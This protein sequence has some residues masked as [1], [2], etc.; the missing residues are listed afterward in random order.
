[1]WASQLRERLGEAGELD[2]TLLEESWASGV[3]VAWESFRASNDRTAAAAVNG[4]SV[5]ELDGAEGFLVSQAEVWSN[6]SVLNARCA[7]GADG[8]TT[9]WLREAMPCGPPDWASASGA[10]ERANQ[11]VVAA[12]VGSM[13]KQRACELLRVSGDSSDAQ[14]KAAYR[15]MVHAW[16]PD[17]MEQSSESERAFAT[18]QMAAINAAYQLLRNDR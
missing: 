18:R 10:A 17:Q 8:Y 14:I 7:H 9:K 2:A 16:H 12:K 6:H 1:M 4:V 13:T 5:A 11:R 3:P 15:R